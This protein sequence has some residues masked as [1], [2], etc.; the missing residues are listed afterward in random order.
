[1]LLI[2]TSL[3]QCLWE[4]QGS[5]KSLGE[6]RARSMGI[7]LCW[8][9]WFFVSLMEVFIWVTRPEIASG[10]VLRN[11]PL[12]PQQ[13]QVMQILLL[14]VNFLFKTRISLLMNI[15]M[16]CFS[17]CFGNSQR[18]IASQIPV[19]YLPPPIHT[20]LRQERSGPCSAGWGNEGCCHLVGIYQ[21]EKQTSHPRLLR[22]FSLRSASVETHIWGQWK[23]K[24]CPPGKLSGGAHAAVTCSLGLTQI[25]CL[26]GRML[27]EAGL[28]CVQKIPEAF[29]ASVLG[30]RTPDMFPLG[31]ARVGVHMHGYTNDDGWHSPLVPPSKLLLLSRQ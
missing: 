18:T 15:L 12:C 13:I 9:L 14:T 4:R 19:S 11:T 28:L 29:F 30:A 10:Q 1:M 25:L 8:R 23:R 3:R 22:K 20:P 7:K 31:Y 5:R 21:A 27:R 6:Q 24:N 26:C 16:I 17:L 2:K